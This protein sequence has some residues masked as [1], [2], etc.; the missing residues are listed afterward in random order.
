MQT[1]AEEKLN[2]NRAQKWVKEG[3]LLFRE[4][5]GKGKN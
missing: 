4:S 1:R 3:L 2:F 5:K